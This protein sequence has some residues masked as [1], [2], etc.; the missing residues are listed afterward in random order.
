MKIQ[1]GHV[2][3]APKVIQ[4]RQIL[5]D[6]FPGVR[7][8]L[9]EDSPG[10]PEKSE[11]LSRVLDLFQNQLAKGTL[12][13]LVAGGETSGSATLMRAL[14]N[15]AAGQNQIMALVDGCDCFDVTAVESRELS[16][17]LW[18]RCADAEQ[19]LKAADLLLRDGNLP[20]ILLDLKLN[21]EIQLRKIPATT[22][23]RLQRLV[24][25]TSAIFV[26]VTPRP[27]IA[28]AQTR[29]T[30]QSGFVLADLE[31]DASDLLQELNWEVADARHAHRIVALHSA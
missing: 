26:A 14:V 25:M 12:N 24:E 3:P 11:G 4:L 15:W 21:P 17:L 18:V 9:E 7:L 2:M 31:R 8:H 6:K 27:L 1:E 29:I 22:W 23:Y 5:A 20:L 10:A 16:R 30:L 13:E 19:A 28:P